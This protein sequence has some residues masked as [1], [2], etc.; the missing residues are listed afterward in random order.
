M[1]ILFYFIA[2]F[3]LGF[4]DGF[5]GISATPQQNILG[6]I[7]AIAVFL[8]TLGIEIRRMHDV[9]KSGWFILIPIY[10]LILSL[11]AGT[12]GENRFGPDPYGTSAPVAPVEPTPSA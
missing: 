3:I 4:I 9:N 10:N 8:P 5:L 7:F 11:T 1:F 6:Y 2:S 12:K